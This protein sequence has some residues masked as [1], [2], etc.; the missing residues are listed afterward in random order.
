MGSVNGICRT[1]GCFT[2]SC[3]WMD[4]AASFAST[5][6]CSVTWN[7]SSQVASTQRLPIASKLCW[8]RK[9]RS[10]RC[11][12]SKLHFAMPKMSS[13]TWHD[14]DS[15]IIHSPFLGNGNIRQ[16]PRDMLLL[17]D[18][19]GQSGHICNGRMEIQQLPEASE[20]GDLRATGRVPA[21]VMVGTCWN[22]PDSV[23]VA[24]P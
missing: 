17:H 11:Y 16:N 7:D 3:W 5:D 13:C 12:C 6:R 22:F 4:V 20:V 21:A 14:Q 24:I 2:A 8:K 10:L 15:S 18:F 9:Q 1:E 23:V 19:A